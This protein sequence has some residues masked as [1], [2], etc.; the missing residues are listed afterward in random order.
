MW[1]L[2]RNTEDMFSHDSRLDME[3]IGWSFRDNFGNFSLKLF[4][5]GEANSR[6]SNGYFQHM[7]V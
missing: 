6:N 3:G 2:V 5:V 1:D 4:V 7:T